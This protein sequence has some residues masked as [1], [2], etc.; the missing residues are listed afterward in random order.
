MFL[1]D[2]YWDSTCNNAYSDN[3]VLFA[4]AI[5]KITGGYIPYYINSTEK[6][7][8]RKDIWGTIMQHDEIPKRKIIPIKSI[9]EKTIL[10]DVEVY[11]QAKVELDAN[12]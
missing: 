8:D 10:D 12:I 6:R 7:E 4:L 3:I 9:S 5:E 1:Q 2:E 11:T